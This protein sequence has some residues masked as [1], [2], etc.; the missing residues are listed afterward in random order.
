MKYLKAI[1]MQ[2]EILCHSSFHPE[3][4]QINYKEL[5]VNRKKMQGF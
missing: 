4:E 1:E 3:P 5:E 2:R